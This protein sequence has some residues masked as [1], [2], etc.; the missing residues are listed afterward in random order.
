MGSWSHTAPWW[1]GAGSKGTIL[2]KELSLSDDIA[3]SQ[4]ASQARDR[5]TK[6]FAAKQFAAVWAGFQATDLH[7]SCPSM[8]KAVVYPISFPFELEGKLVALGPRG[9][10]EGAVILEAK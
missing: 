1:G 7:R 4:K 9:V 3:S 8:G 2:S 10:G 6:K 5:F